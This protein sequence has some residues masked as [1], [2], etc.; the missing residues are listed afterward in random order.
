MNECAYMWNLRWIN[1]KDSL[2]EIPILLRL[3]QELKFQFSTLI[4]T[5]QRNTKMCIPHEAT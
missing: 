2:S 1:L 5:K 4:S 3:T